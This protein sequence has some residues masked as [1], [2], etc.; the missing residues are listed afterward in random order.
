MN[1]FVFFPIIDPASHSYR[2]HQIL[3]LLD[4]GNSLNPEDPHLPEWKTQSVPHLLGH[5]DAPVLVHDDGLRGGLLIKRTIGFWAFDV[6]TTALYHIMTFSTYL[7][8]YFRIIEF[9][10]SE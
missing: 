9:M 1:V 10:V 2:D 8:G 7:G 5:S 3:R 6:H 4:A